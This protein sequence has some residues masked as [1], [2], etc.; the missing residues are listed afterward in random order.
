[1]PF[2]SFYINAKYKLT[3][4]IISPEAYLSNESYKY[5]KDFR[6]ISYQYFILHLQWEQLQQSSWGIYQGTNSC[7]AGILKL[8][9]NVKSG[10]EHCLLVLDY[11]TFV[12]HWVYS[13]LAI[14]VGMWRG[15]WCSCIY[16]YFWNGEQGQ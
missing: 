11:L 4:F 13:L 15:I 9:F 3:S 7:T 12:L 10:V 5:R 2:F 6:Y 16:T 1:M 8:P 14:H